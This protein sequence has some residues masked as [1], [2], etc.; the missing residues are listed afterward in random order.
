MHKVGTKLF[1]QPFTRIWEWDWIFTW[2]LL[3]TT[4]CF[5][6]YVMEIFI[7]FCMLYVQQ[8]SI[9]VVLSKL[10]TVKVGTCGYSLDFQN[11]LH[12]LFHTFKL[13]CTLLYQCNQ[14]EKWVPAWCPITK[15][16]QT[17]PEKLGEP[18][19]H[20]CHSACEDQRCRCAN[21]CHMALPARASQCQWHTGVFDLPRT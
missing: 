13:C 10:D 14:K 20:L 1:L 7:F 5:M 11:G 9:S 15:V 8:V 19:I 21:I 3:S 12:L 16:F 4:V 2:H 6:Y 17:P 18:Y